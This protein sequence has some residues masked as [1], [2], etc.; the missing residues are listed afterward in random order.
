MATTKNVLIV[1]GTGFLGYHAIQAFLAKGWRVTA[2][3]LPPA[4]PPDL[5]PPA[6][7]VVLLDLEQASDDSLLGLLRG[8][9]ALVFAAG[10][11]DRYGQKKPAYPAFRHANV[12][13]P[14]RLLGLARQAGVQRAVILGS[15]FAFFSRLWPGMRLGE[16]HPYIRSRIEQEE[17]LT[18]IPGLDVCV[19]ELPYIFGSLPVPGWKPLWKPLVRYL[20]SSRLIPYV[21]G[22][23]ACVSAV[24]VGRAIYAA[25]ERGEAGRCYPIGQENLTW[26]EML[27]RLASADDRQIRVITLPTWPVRLGLLGL[28]LVHE[29]QRKE[30]GLD[31]RSFISLQTAETFIDPRESQSILG[32]E[33]ED[34]DQAFTATV[35]AC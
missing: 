2:L 13:V 16:R 28:W 8:H 29:V 7:K 23:T 9:Q 20:R 11:D 19:L 21:K 27:G 6:V 22:G 10:L 26:G 34:L 5:Y 1:G 32:F 25:I 12:E 14:L 35:S 33:S 4:P 24:T 30:A 3:G 15:Y 31:L 18:G 17:A